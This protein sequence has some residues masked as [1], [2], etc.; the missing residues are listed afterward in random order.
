MNVSVRN[1]SQ[2][3]IREIIE[4]QR[5]VY[6]EVSNGSLYAP[7]FLEKHLLAFPEGQFCAEIDGLIVGSA[8]NLI[9]SLN[10]EYQNHRWYDIVGYGNSTSHSQKG[11]S[12]YADDI[13]TDPAYRRL[14]IGTALMDA[15][16]ELCLKMS[17]KRIIGGARLYNYCLYADHLPVEEYARLVT[18][19]EIIDPVLSFDIK[20]G[21]KHIKILSNYIADFRSL[22]FASFI[23]WKNE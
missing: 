3:D 14:G 11:D 10:P 13:V 7:L 19:N 6:P 4:F 8:T 18:N 16:K 20:N 21:F 22:N 5:E 23:E 9:V 1:I 2:A 12:L 17:L 15:R